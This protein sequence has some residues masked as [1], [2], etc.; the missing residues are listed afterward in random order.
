MPLSR[1]AATGRWLQ[2]VARCLTGQRGAAYPKNVFKQTETANELARL[3]QVA[4]VV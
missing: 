4:P 1:E 3:A 2:R